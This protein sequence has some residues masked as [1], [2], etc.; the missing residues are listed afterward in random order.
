MDIYV[1]DA[2]TFYSKEYSLSRKDTTTQSYIDDPRFEVIGVAVQKNGGIPEWFSGTHTEI[3]AWLETFEFEKAAVCCHNMLF[4]G[5]ILA[6]K[7][8]IYP[9]L[10]LCTLSM[11]RAKHGVDAGGSLAKLAERY[12]LGVK[13]TEVVDAMGKRRVDFSQAE[14]ARYGEY[15]K[16]DVTLTYDLFRRSEEHTSELQSH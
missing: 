1:L 2:E 11:A 7:F 13:G 16:N 15:C 12:Q 3:K 10:L 9:K 8:G 5:T 4:D 14:L 6:W